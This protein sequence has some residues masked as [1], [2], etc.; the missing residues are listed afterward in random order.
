MQTRPDLKTAGAEKN[1][2]ISQEVKEAYDKLKKNLKRNP[3]K[4]ELI[5]ATG[6]NAEAINT[7]QK[8]FKLNFFNKPG[9]SALPPDVLKESV[10]KGVDK[11]RAKKEITQPSS[12]VEE[13]KLKKVNFPNKKMEDAF[14]AN[15]ELYHSFPQGST[16]AK[17]VGATLDSF[18]Q[19]YP[20]GVTDDV[21]RRHVA[22]FRNKLN[23]K[24]PKQEYE[25]QYKKQKIINK[26]REKLIKEVSGFLQE[27]KIGKAKRELGFGRSGE[28]LD[29]AHRA[30]L[31]Q[32]KDFGLDYLTDNLGLDTR[33][34]NQE[35]LPPLE[36]EINSLHKERMKLIKGI[37]PG[38]VPKEVSKKLEDINIKLSN[39]SMKD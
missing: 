17:K 36:N 4:N 25:G 32:F 34:I 23:L 26:R 39:I 19:F 11:R 13:G 37:K 1:K 9:V 8:T 6:R 20:D 3:T 14:K 5:R 10:Q 28:N 12:F 30:S 31:K 27:R 29:L 2:A 21:L 22:F 16:E 18:K 15:V 38:E 33:I 35:I 7:A 24:F